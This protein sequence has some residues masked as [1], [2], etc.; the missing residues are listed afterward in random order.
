MEL[1]GWMVIAGAASAIVLF[2]MMLGLVLSRFYQRA[3][4]DEAQ[5]GLLP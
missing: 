4:A 5:P 1:Q 2:V 3:A